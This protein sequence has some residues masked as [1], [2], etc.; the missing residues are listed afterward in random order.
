MV[1][2]GDQPLH[3]R[4]GRLRLHIDGE[5]VAQLFGIGEGPGFGDLLDEEVE[6]IIDSHVGDQ[7]DF[8]LELGHR[9]GKDETG[10]EIA[11]GI[12]LRVDEMQ[13]RRDPKRMTQD[14][15]LG[16]RRRLQPYDLGLQIDRS[17]IFV[18]CQMIDG[19]FDRHAYQ[20][21]ASGHE[22]DFPTKSLAGFCG[23]R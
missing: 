4:T 2:I 15:G 1:D 3:Q 16:M 22:N 6:G 10:Q 23:H 13:V 17:V 8:D 12:L 5:I 20:S 19:G 21:L 9:L 7:I 11:V 18:M 14:L